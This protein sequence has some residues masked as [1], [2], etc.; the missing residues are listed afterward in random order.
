MTNP[1]RSSSRWLHSGALAPVSSA[2]FPS[3]ACLLALAATVAM[4]L[5]GRPSPLGAQD[6]AWSEAAGALIEFEEACREVEA[7][8]PVP[9]CGPVL[10]VDPASR[11]A[12]SNQADGEGTL[13]RRGDVYVGRLPEG[14]PVA[15]TA[16]E[17][18]NRRWAMVML[19]LPEDRF[20]R[21]QLL[22]HE[23]F[24]RIQPELGH[25]VTDPLA[26]HLDEEPGRLWL[27]LEIRAL[28][29]ALEREEAE[30][31][32]AARDALLFR[33]VRHRHYP[34][35]A[36]I[37][38]ALEG[39]EG[40]AEYTGM[41]FA[42]AATGEGPERA[43]SA[44]ARFEDRPTYVR[45][46]G[47]GTGPALGLLLDRY[48]SGWRTGLAGTPDLAGSLAAVLSFL[49]PTTDDASLEELGRSR[50]T[51]YGFAA[52]QEEEAERAARMEE[53]RERYRRE[54]VDGPVLTLDLPERRLMFNPNTVLSL[55][56]LGNVY[57]GAVLLGPW[58]ELTI[59]EGA[60]LASED[61]DR[62]RV[63]APES[64]NVKED[65]TLDGPGWTLRLDPHWRAV[66]GP[67]PGDVRLESIPDPGIQS[68]RLPGSLAGP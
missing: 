63:M 45:S 26:T 23:S 18:S 59:H 6:V 43:A 8:W 42:L 50:A 37:E 34:G 47:Y 41:R 67:R 1:I 33:A 55:G 15:N 40:L 39:H 4:L 17:W 14:V 66:P 53:L 12:V 29:R 36:R 20:R 64:L 19:P 61:R 35:A 56:D 27:R 52:I 25:N 60:A 7:A 65:G 21:L 57:P 32:A 24:H 49:P 22:A 51:E 16:M 13:E 11:L 54:L 5:F 2:D 9:L 38:A 68:S 58:G 3:A 48:D 46:L 44:V 62:A 30:A 10:L 31:R 28:A